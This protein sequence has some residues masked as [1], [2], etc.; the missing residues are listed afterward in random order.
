[1]SK[2]D[3]VLNAEQQNLFNK[4][5]TERKSIFFT[6]SGGTGKSYLYYNSYIMSMQ[7]R[8]L[9][10]CNYVVFRQNISSELIPCQS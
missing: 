8:N 9:S 4:V 2:K 6:G 7:S 3:I 10:T 5:V 1:M